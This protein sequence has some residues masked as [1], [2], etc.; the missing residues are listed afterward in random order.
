MN[1]ERSSSVDALEDFKIGGQ[2]T[3]IHDTMNPFID[4]PLMKGGGSAYGGKWKPAKPA[5]ERFIGKPG[6]IKQSQTSKGDPIE[7]HIGPDGRADYE[8]HYS[9]H[10]SPGSHQ[11]PHQ[12]PITWDD[13]GPHLDRA[14]F[15]GKQHQIA[16]WNLKMSTL[17]GTNSL[18]DNRFKTISDFKWCMKRGGEVQFDWKGVSY[19]CFGCVRQNPGQ[20]P[21]MVI[22]QAGTAEVN[23]RTEKWCDTPDEL[24][25]YMVGGD[26]LRA[27]ITQV[28]AWERT[29]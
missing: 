13:I 11:I 29:I 27:V 19:C 25:E 16:R 1:Y 21:R 24:L 17:V 15:P 3:F 22:C 5:D 9:D 28:T 18:E 26:R 2:P 7:T 14:D 8:I 10:G 23:A 4:V 12:Y 20:A 6:E